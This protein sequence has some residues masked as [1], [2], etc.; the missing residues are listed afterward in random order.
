VVPVSQ[1]DEEMAASGSYASP[2]TS[3][4]VG[5]AEAAA[6]S[7]LVADMLKEHLAAWEL[8]P[9]ELDV[10][11]S[12]A[13]GYG[14][15]SVVYLGRLRGETIV[16]VKDCQVSDP[17]IDRD[18]ISVYLRELEVWSRMNHPNIL[19]FFGFCIKER[20]FQICSEYCRGGTL[21]DLLHNCW[22]VPLRWWQRRKI[23][24]DVSLAVEHMHTLQTPV[25]HRDLKSLNVLLLS[26]VTDESARPSVKLADFGFARVRKSHRRDDS[27]SSVLTE[28]VGTPHWMAPEVALGS[29]RYHEKVDVFSFAILIY[30]VV[31]RYMAFEDL[32]PDSARQEIASGGRPRLDPD[33]V[34]PE[35]PA[36]LLDLMV[37]CWDQDPSKRPSMSEVHDQ[38]LQVPWPND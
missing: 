12:L 20:A 25:M 23:L 28:G 35:A 6:C 5:A 38:L 9:G 29:T 1:C 18:V 34:P 11:R 30:E 21:F 33:I 36:A 26:P 32:D 3:A 7:S 24:V 31:C 4:A 13:V 22:H 37:R 2:A 16:A 10:D 19:H 17:D 8:K 14:S 15:T 27:T